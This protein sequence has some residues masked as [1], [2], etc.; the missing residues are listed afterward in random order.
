MQQ[1]KMMKLADNASLAFIWIALNRSPDKVD[2]IV[3]KVKSVLQPIEDSLKP[4][5]ND[6][7][8]PYNNHWDD[9]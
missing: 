1:K 6:L 7:P 3:A 5:R 9:I 8:K 2:E 4:N